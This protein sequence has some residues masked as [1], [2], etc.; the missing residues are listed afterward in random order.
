M[1]EINLKPHFLPFCSGIPW[2]ERVEALGWTV[3]DK[4][5]Y[6]WGVRPSAY[7]CKEYGAILGRGEY[8]RLKEFAEEEGVNINIYF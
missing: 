2:I 7:Y 3:S 8:E 4:V 1:E 5:K 6:H